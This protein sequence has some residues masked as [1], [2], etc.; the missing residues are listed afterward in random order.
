MPE[1]QEMVEYSKLKKK[2]EI[3]ISNIFS[4]KKTQITRIKNI[5]NNYVERFYQGIRYQQNNENENKTICTK[6]KPYKIS[7]IS[8]LYVT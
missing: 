4:E 1:N 6:I 8:F 2:I 5:G 7:F 3:Y